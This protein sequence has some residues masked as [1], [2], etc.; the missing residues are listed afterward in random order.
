MGAA[1]ISGC[2]HTLGL[3][4]W[5]L[6]KCIFP[7]PFLPPQIGAWGNYWFPLLIHYIEQE[8]QLKIKESDSTALFGTCKAS[9]GVLCLVGG[10]HLKKDVDRLERLKQNRTA[11][12][13]PW[14]ML[15]GL[16]MWGSQL[17]GSLHM[18][19]QGWECKGA[20]SWPGL[21]DQSMPQQVAPGGRE[22]SPSPCSNHGSRAG[23]SLLP[24]KGDIVPSQSPPWQ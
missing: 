24:G 17:L 14:A 21:C 10:L 19:S 1:L 16:H 13:Q 12:G 8:C 4:M 5:L 18:W 15:G 7:S 3:I 23:D 2:H 22:P 6:Q 20:L 9:P 11:P